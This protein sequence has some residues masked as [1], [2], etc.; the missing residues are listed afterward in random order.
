MAIIPPDPGKVQGVVDNMFEQL[1]QLEAM[2]SEHKDS[3]LALELHA[4]RVFLE[5][6]AEQRGTPRT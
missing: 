1:A 6:I 4:V 3:V 2:A 5:R